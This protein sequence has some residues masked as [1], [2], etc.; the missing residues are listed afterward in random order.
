MK[1][2]NHLI[3][4]ALF[5][6]GLSGPANA[7]TTTDRYGSSGLLGTSYIGGTFDYIDFR[8]PAVRGGKGSRL[9]LNHAITEN[10]DVSADYSYAYARIRP[11]VGKMQN[12][13]FFTDG[14][15]VFRRHGSQP[16]IRG[17]VGRTLAY[18]PGPN[19]REW[20]YRTEAGVEMPVGRHLSLTP[21]V[22]YTDGFRSRVGDKFEGGLATQAALSENVSMIARASRA[23]NRDNS[24]SVG[25]ALP[26]GR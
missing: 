23:D 3:T 8:D 9:F 7:A 19:Q 13:Q 15:F 5:A 16:Y 2:I 18:I 21:F 14:T 10:V 25:L 26:F 11:A 22:R 24:F 17:G 12:H 1:R 4:V 6:A 20:H